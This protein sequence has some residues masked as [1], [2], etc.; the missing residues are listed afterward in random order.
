M[1][2]VKPRRPQSL[3]SHLTA[4]TRIDMSG[5]RFQCHFRCCKKPHLAT[6]CPHVPYAYTKI[7]IHFSID[8]YEEEILCSKKCEQKIQL[9]SPE[10]MHKA[11]HPEMIHES[12]DFIYKVSFKHRAGD[13]EA[14]QVPG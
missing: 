4:E 8:I 9:F 3:Y 13:V 11:Q 7:S 1:L 12:E 6:L 5:N 2:I 10:N 14:P